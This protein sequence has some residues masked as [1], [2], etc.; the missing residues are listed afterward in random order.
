MAEMAGNCTHVRVPQ[1]AG[2]R[3]GKNTWLTGFAALLLLL[4]EACASGG[5]NNIV[6]KPHPAGVQ[7]LRQEMVS[8]LE[9]HGYDRVSVRKTSVDWG[10][11]YLDSSAE[12]WQQQGAVIVTTSEYAMLFRSQENPALFVRVRIKRE[13]GWTKL[14]FLEEGRDGLSEASKRRLYALRG[15]L[16]LRYGEER[17]QVK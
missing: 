13:S 14:I 11:G 17:V 10:S 9:E 2:G 7:M 3:P 4:L 8:V 16:V 1:S 15:S 5:G 6:V 12:Q